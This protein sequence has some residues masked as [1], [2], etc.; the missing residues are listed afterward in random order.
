MT[1]RLIMNYHS[2]TAKRASITRLDLHCQ[3]MEF[4][5]TEQQVPMILRLIDL[6]Y[7]LQ[8][9]Q[10][11]TNKEK[12]SVPMEDSENPLNG[13]YLIFIKKTKKLCFKKLC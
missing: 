7:L 11:P 13:H 8:S 12:L 2:T 1:I 4:S 5:I 3:K 6:L 9:R 10:V